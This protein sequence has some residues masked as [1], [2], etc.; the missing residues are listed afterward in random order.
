MVGLY[1]SDMKMMPC[2]VD[3]Q[4]MRTVNLKKH[5]IKEAWNSAKFEEF[6]DYFRTACHDCES[7][8]LCM[9]GCL[10]RPEI[11]ICKKRAAQIY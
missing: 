1:L 2:S 9:G 4:E 8:R 10:I 5:T 11:V 3:N 6:R 7:W